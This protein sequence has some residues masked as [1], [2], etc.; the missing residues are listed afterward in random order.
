M[1]LLGGLADMHGEGLPLSYLFIVADVDAPLHTK[2]VT[3]SKLDNGSEFPWNHP[4]THL[5]QQGPHRNK[6]LGRAWP[7]SRHQIYQ[8][9]IL[10]ALKRRLANN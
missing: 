8:I 10:I 4:G 2:K 5:I 1:E 9:H 7:T 6:A 3:S